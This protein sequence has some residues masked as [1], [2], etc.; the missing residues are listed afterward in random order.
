MDFSVAL[1]VV[2]SCFPVESIPDEDHL[3][4]AVKRAHV[5]P[6]TLKPTSAA[7]RNHGTGLSKGM[8]TDWDRYASPVDTQ[9]RLGNPEMHGVVVMSVEK[10][11]GIAI[12]SVIHDPVCQ[13]QA[14]TNVT[15]PKS[16]DEKTE[17][18][19]RELIN[20][21]RLALIELSVWEIRADPL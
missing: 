4:M 5:D 18:E 21:S 6:I 11:R 19:S 10:I 16:K 7:Y 2:D 9:N 13:N 17:K 14:H 8:S 1:S 15:G 12:Y 3:Y 20:Q